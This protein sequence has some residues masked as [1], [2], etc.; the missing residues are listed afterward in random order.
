MRRA[1]EA[2]WGVGAAAFVVVRWLLAVCNVPAL[3]GWLAGASWLLAAIVVVAQLGSSS[4]TRPRVLGP[5]GSRLLLL[6]AVLNLAGL[7]LTA[8][9]GTP[10]EWQAAVARGLDLLAWGWVLCGAPVAA[11]WLWG[12]EPTAAAAAPSRPARR[13]LLLSA[14]ILC[15]LGLQVAALFRPRPTWW[16][17]IDYPLYS[18][19]HFPP[20]RTAH[21]RL[22]GLTEQG[23]PELFEITAQDLGMSWFVYHTQ[24]V[25]RLF[26]RPWRADDEFLRALGGSQ[27][28]PLRAVTS[29]RTVFE[30]Q[31]GRIRRF[32]ELRQLTFDLRPPGSEARG[33]EGP[34]SER[35]DRSSGNE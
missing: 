17:F 21:Y 20:A 28:P 10:T 24:L 5:G 26:E 18:P 33:G 30:L 7:S 13:H 9:G 16:P 12:P 29:E 19:A 22:H 6:T 1:L 25:P 34:V 2:T 11:R 14:L 35:P 27:L 8:V 15:V 31:D 32:P 3:C 4:A 23:S